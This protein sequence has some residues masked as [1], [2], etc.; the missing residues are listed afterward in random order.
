M[1]EFSSQI[2][3]SFDELIGAPFEASSVPVELRGFDFSC[4]KWRE[5]G[6]IEGLTQ[7]GKAGA[8]HRCVRLFEQEDTQ[9]R[10]VMADP[11]DQVGKA[12]KTGVDDRHQRI[13]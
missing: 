7:G 13:E 4:Q 5:F 2:F 6:D 12:G 3:L 11:F 9:P 8:I 1:L 10:A